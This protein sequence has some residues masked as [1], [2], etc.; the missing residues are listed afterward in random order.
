MPI[1]AVPTAQPGTDAGIAGGGA[2]LRRFAA[3]IRALLSDRESEYA[4]H[5][6]EQE[7]EHVQDWSGGEREAQ[8]LL[9]AALAHGDFRPDDP[10]GTAEFAQRAAEA[11]RECG[12]VAG[13]VEALQVKVQAFLVAGCVDEAID[14]AK[15]SS[16]RCS[17]LGEPCAWTITA[18]A[19]AFLLDGRLEE[20][21]SSAQEASNLLEQAVDAGGA[22]AA[23]AVLVEA[24]LVSG[25][26]EAAR[27]V[28]QEARRLAEE[29]GDDRALAI[30][31][32]K[33]A[34]ICNRSK[35]H[36]ES[37]R[38][39][40]KALKLWGKLNDPV[41]EVD[42][43]VVEAV[44]KLE[45]C[46]SRGPHTCNNTGL[47]VLSCAKRAFNQA[48]RW[49]RHDH[50]CLGNARMVH[51]RAL[52]QFG[53]CREAETQLKAATQAF[54]KAR[55]HRSRAE[56]LL[57]WSEASLQ[58][59]F[60]QDARAQSQR[61]LEL[62]EQFGDIEGQAKV[63]EMNAR[64]DQAHDPEAMEKKLQLEDAQRK[65]RDRLE[66]EMYQAMRAEAEEAF[67][68]VE[69]GSP[70]EQN[71]WRAE[72]A[73][74]FKGMSGGQNVSSRGQELGVTAGIDRS[75]IMAKVTQSV[76]TI[77]G[78]GEVVEADLPL[79]EAGITSNSA[80]LLRDE[81]IRE[82]PGISLPPTLIFDYPS[83]GEIAGYIAHQLGA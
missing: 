28:A 72:M 44:A 31:Y 52:M 45:V 82:I 54:R 83:I 74:L 21:V 2:E 71:D 24:L 10:L 78:G 14:A 12:D 62:F 13:E 58:R 67:K 70:G 68:A 80:V 73:K 40:E 60:L 46:Q 35:Q 22:A 39:A 77:V 63:Q 15:A 16:Q 11:L 8:V 65:E 56:A 27:E 20:A 49:R 47:N 76:Y 38:H 57:L 36:V 5:L 61:A 42:M 30:A 26:H 3:Q 9:L 19:S 41:N 79:M 43:L 55:Q 69:R 17:Q 37:L 23:R 59:G 50:A 1:P 7:L 34:M 29:S 33:L 6:V 53:S 4:L 51:G 25:D 32:S 48:E 75:L 18:T 66:A 64:I 81:L